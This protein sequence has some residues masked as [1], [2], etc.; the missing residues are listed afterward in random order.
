MELDNIMKD[1]EK[2]LALLNERFVYFEETSNEELCEALQAKGFDLSVDKI[3][4]QYETCYNVDELYEY[5]YQ[6]DEK[7][8]DELDSQKLLIHSDIF[9]H[10]LHRILHDHYDMEQVGDLAYITGYILDLDPRMNDLV[11][12]QQVETYIKMIIA[13]AKK[14]QVNEVIPLFKRINIERCLKVDVARCLQYSDR[15]QAVIHEFNQYY[16]DVKL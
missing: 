3:K 5:L 2:A 7:L 4:A 15:L 14:N 8:W 13:Y 9:G 1:I 10:L 11:Y 12:E 16:K 6:R